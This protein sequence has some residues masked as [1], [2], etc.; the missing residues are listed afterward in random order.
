MGVVFHG[1]LCHIFQMEVEGNRG[2]FVSGHC[3]VL[4]RRRWWGGSFMSGHCVVL[5]RRRWWGGSF[6]SG[7]CVV[8]KGVKGNGGSFM[9]GRCV[10]L[11]RRRWG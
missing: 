2:S 7:R 1:Q 5:S 6:M 11:P 8:Q 3:V 10:M 9:G 4:S